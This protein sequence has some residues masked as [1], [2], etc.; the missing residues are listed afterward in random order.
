[1]SREEREEFGKKLETMDEEEEEEHSPLISVLP[2]WQAKSH[3][4]IL[5]NS[6]LRKTQ[7][8]TTLK[9]LMSQ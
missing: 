7:K 6:P 8:G 2:N 5:I 3:H 4:R 9:T 1:M